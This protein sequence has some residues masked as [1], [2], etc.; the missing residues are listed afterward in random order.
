LPYN[1]R[2]PWGGKRDTYMVMLRSFRTAVGC[3]VPLALGAAASAAT[4]EIEGKALLEKNCARCHSIAA[5]GDSPLKGAPPLREVYL[6]KPIEMLEQGLEEGLGS[7]HPGMPQVQFSVEQTDAILTYLGSL[8]G[9]PP[10]RAHQ[11]PFRLL[12]TRLNRRNRAHHIGQIM[13]WSRGMMP[14]A[15][16]L[17]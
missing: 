8:V 9:R 13:P 2:A 7:R 1:D 17:A 3:L 14:L 12:R 10:R 11:R 5:T 16:R 15:A 6:S 4:P